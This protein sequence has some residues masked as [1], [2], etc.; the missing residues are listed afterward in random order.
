MEYLV[1]ISDSKCKIMKLTFGR[2]FRCIKQLRKSKINDSFGTKKKSSRPSTF[3]YNSSLG[4]VGSDLLWGI[5]RNQIN[6]NR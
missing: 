1:T 6:S 3:M 5:I 4:G 2:L